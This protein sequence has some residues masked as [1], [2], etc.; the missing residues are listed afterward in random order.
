MFSEGSE[1]LA[2]WRSQE[3]GAILLNSAIQTVNDLCSTDSDP[4]ASARNPSTAPSD[5]STA[6]SSH[7]SAAIVFSSAPLWLQFSSAKL[8]PFQLL[9]PWALSSC[10]PTLLSPS[11]LLLPLLE[12]WPIPRSGFCLSPEDKST[13]GSQWS[14]GLKVLP[15]G[16]PDYK[17]SRRLTSVARRRSSLKSKG[18][19]FTNLLEAHPHSCVCHFEIIFDIKVDLNFFLIF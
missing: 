14:P 12:F 8:C 2:G 13:D 17:I 9:S 16:W 3:P 1:L 7:T 15:T 19:H 4:S 5:P 11:S 18:G 6:K 10:R